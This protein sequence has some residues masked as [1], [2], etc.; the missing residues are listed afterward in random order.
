MM[1]WGDMTME[2]KLKLKPFM[3]PYF[4][5]AELPPEKRQDGY[6]E[7]PSFPLSALDPDTLG[8]MCDEFR[9]RIFAAAGKADSREEPKP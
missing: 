6:K 2:I 7:P 4:V 9:R 1:R 5:I 8:A 3:V